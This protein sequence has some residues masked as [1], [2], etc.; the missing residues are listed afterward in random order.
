M[1]QVV[2]PPKARVDPDL[3]V[4]LGLSTLPLNQFRPNSKAR[5]RIVN[6]LVISGGIGDYICYFQGIRWV[7]ATYPHIIGRI[8][9]SEHMLELTQ[10]FFK[11]FPRWEVRDRAIIN[12]AFLKARPTFAPLLQPIN[13]TGAHPLDLGF[14]YYANVN[15]PPKDWNEYPRIDLSALEG[16]KCEKPYA[17]MTPG[18]TTENRTM[19]AEAFNG[20]KDHLIARGITPIFL[21]K[22]QITDVRQIRYES[23]YNFEG[24]L[25]LREQTSLLQAAGIMSKAT[26]VVGLDNGLLHLAACTDVPIIF[27]YNIASP[28][29]RRPRRKVGDIWE[30][31]PD[32]KELPCT[33]CQSRMRYM[34]DH[35]FALCL[36]KDNACLDA[37]ADPKPW[38]DAVDDVLAKTSKVE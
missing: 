28:E 16:L 26:L 29:H 15:P 14:I 9:V 33:F 20:I 34:F 36:Y 31:Y 38:C 25:D 13:A 17:V 21:G 5:D 27:G 1:E 11:E 22:K 2:S 37:L 32:V 35:D 12:E 7:A 3:T 19:R 30:I 10:Q 8:Y 6:F 24:G 18:A 4:S 23:G